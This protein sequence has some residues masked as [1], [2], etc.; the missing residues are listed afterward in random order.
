MKPL[1]GTIQREIHSLYSLLCTEGGKKTSRKEF[2]FFFKNA[3]LQ[4][5]NKKKQ[6]LLLL[7]VN[8]PFFLISGLI[9]QK[10]SKERNSSFL[11]LLSK[12]KHA[13]DIKIG[14]LSEI[15]A[16]I[17]LFFSF[18]PFFLTPQFTPSH[19]ISRAQYKITRAFLN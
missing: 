17:G 3:S 2:K 19:D 9:Y 4:D 7:M 11:Y 13:K 15:C 12:K 6:G 10:Q 5:C 16:L 18:V 14:K 8:L 1:K